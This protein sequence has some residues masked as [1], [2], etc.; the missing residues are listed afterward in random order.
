VPL[1]GFAAMLGAGATR[2]CLPVNWN[3][4]RVVVVWLMMYDSMIKQAQTDNTIA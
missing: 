3:N 2:L 1:S 4:V